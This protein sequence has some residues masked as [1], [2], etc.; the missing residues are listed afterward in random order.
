MW[1]ESLLVFILFKFKTR[2]NISGIQVVIQNS[3]LALH[4]T[5]VV[6]GPLIVS[7]FGSERLH[8]GA[9]NTERGDKEL[10]WNI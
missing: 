2:T 6:L 8:G 1:F 3:S 9:R 5:F 7:W 4:F 10:L